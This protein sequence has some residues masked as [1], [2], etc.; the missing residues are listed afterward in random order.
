MLKLLVVSLLLTG[1]TVLIHGVG[2][3]YSVLHITRLW[4]KMKCNKRALGVE[5]VIIRLILFLLLLHL[6][7]AGVWALFYRLSQALP[8]YETAAYY[9]L[10]SYTT[11]GYGDV[12]LLTKWR[13]LGPIEAAAGVLMMGWSTGVIVTVILK[14][15]TSRLQLNMTGREKI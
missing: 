15:Y 6:V 4:D 9:S 13:L 14:A 11:V 10:T 2:T 5:I 1:I 7:E 8:N 3:L 12:V